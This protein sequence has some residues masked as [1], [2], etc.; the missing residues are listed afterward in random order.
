[1]QGHQRPSSVPSIRMLRRKRRE[2]GM[3]GRHYLRVHSEVIFHPR[4]LEVQQNV[5]TSSYNRSVRFGP[6]HPLASNDEDT[7]TA[8]T[9]SY[10]TAKKMRIFY[11]FCTFFLISLLYLARNRRSF[12]FWQHDIRANAF[13]CTHKAFDAS[14]PPKRNN[15]ECDSILCTENLLQFITLLYKLQI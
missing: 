6:Y 14:V 8:C 5:R 7:S 3:V 4:R 13:Y 9:G 10:C 2:V 11:S 12:Y 15:N 1:M